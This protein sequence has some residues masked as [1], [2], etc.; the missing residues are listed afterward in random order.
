MTSKELLYVED[1]LGHEQY[2]QTKC[3]EIVQNIQDA[4]LR[5]TVQTMTGKH[6][7]IF[8]SFLNLL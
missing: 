8:N 2:F 5:N 6:Q 7:Q 3:N 4:E 1:A